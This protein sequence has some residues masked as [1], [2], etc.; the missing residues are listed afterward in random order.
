MT[1]AR[2]IAS[3][4]ASYQVAAAG[5]TLSRRCGPGASGHLPRCSWGGPRLH[6][7]LALCPRFVAAPNQVLSVVAPEYLDV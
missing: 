3:E 5:C 4:R 2:R 1:T 7:C 6:R